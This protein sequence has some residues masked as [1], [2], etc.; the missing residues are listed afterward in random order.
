MAIKDIPDLDAAGAL[1]GTDLVP[2]TQ[3]SSTAKK[4]TLTDLQSFV[5]GAVA[6]SAPTSGATITTAA[7][8]RRR[9][10]DPAA[11]IA[12]L[13]ITLP[14][15]PIDGQEWE[16]IFSNTVTTLTVNGAGGE[17]VSGGGIMQAAHSSAKWVYRS[18][19]TRWFRGN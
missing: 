17:T 1:A 3:G 14:P 5:L 19:G 2:M 6:Y 7:D 8:E 9:I 4:A 10:I 11:A 13:T 18:T 15:D 12:A 16:G